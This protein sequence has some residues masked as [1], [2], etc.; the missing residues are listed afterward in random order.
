MCPA[1]INLN[2]FYE[3]LPRLSLDPKAR[4]EY[5][6][7]S[8][9]SLHVLDSPIYNNRDF[10]LVGG[11]TL[12]DTIHRDEWE[13][14]AWRIQLSDVNDPSGQILL[15]FRIQ[16]YLEYWDEKKHR[17]RS[18]HPVLKAIRPRNTVPH[19]Y[20]PFASYSES[21]R[22]FESAILTKT[23]AEDIAQ[24]LCDVLNRIPSNLPSFDA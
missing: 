3:L 13:T 7:A 8:T 21:L 2:H 19:W 5:T 14:K 24:L 10:R 18:A 17:P 16:P 12:E 6:L 4:F 9:R 22:L 20:S 1:I 15:P 23:D 11:I